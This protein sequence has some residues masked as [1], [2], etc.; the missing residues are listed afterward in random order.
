MPEVSPDNAPIIYLLLAAMLFFTLMAAIGSSL[1]GGGLKRS[2]AEDLFNAAEEKHREEIEKLQE[3]LVETQET[4]AAS[5]Q[6]YSQQIQNLNGELHRSKTDMERLL[7][8]AS[9]ES[10]VAISDEM[11]DLT[12]LI[13]DNNHKNTR[14]MLNLHASLATLQDEV[15]RASDR[16]NKALEDIAVKQREQKA[17]A[18]VQMCDALIS[19]LGTLKSSISQQIDREGSTEGEVVREALTGAGDGAEWESPFAG[20]NGL[21][22]S[23]NDAVRFDD[24]DEESAEEDEEEY[25]DGEATDEDDSDEY[26]EYDED[27]DEDAEEEGEELEEDDDEGEGEDDADDEGGDED[28]DDEDGESADGVDDDGDDEPP[29]KPLVF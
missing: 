12:L 19:S 5:R 7:R 18:T 1:K 29:V 26:A 17:Q 28:A 21:D 8:D 6:E 25:E 11:E 15:R 14:D 10:T 2:E 3:K 23:G 13:S 4:L 9:R 22:S 24:E 27:E 20:D 16:V